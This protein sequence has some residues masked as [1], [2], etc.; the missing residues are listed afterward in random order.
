MACC[1]SGGE[2]GLMHNLYR[3]LGVP[4]AASQEQIQQAFELL[5]M[6]YDP[7]HYL[8]FG[9]WVW[10]RNHYKVIEC[11]YRILSDPELRQAYDRC[12]TRRQRRR[13]SRAWKRAPRCPGKENTGA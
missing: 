2:I 7:E 12:R 10:A 8:D 1:L 11:A 9:E 6:A 13:F 3:I 5:A 4:V